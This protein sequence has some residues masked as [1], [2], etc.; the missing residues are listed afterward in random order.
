[1]PDSQDGDRNPREGFPQQ[2]GCQDVDDTPMQQECQQDEN[3][4]DD[5]LNGVDDRQLIETFVSLQ[6][7]RGGLVYQVGEQH[8]PIKWEQTCNRNVF[9]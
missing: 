5:A 9:G 2:V 1:M 6:D 7:A 8:Q 4:G 3:E